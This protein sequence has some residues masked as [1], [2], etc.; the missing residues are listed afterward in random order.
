MKTWMTTTSKKIKPAVGAG[1][2][3]W[4]SPPTTKLASQVYNCNTM[5]HWCS[6]IMPMPAPLC[7]EL[8]QNHGNHLTKSNLQIQCSP[9]KIPTPFFIDLE[10]AILKFIG[11]TKKPRIAK[12]TLNNK[13][14]SLE[15]TIPDLNLYYRAIVIKTAWNWYRYRQVHH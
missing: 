7:V 13:R 10:R 6:Q 2:V 14:I 15:I 3:W 12:G 8:Q 5:I 9:I 11:I 1:P 4:H